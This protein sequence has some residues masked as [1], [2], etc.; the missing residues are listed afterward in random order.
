MPRFFFHI[1]DDQGCVPD[2]EGIV[3]ANMDEAWVEALR[4]ARD[5][6]ADQLRDDKAMEGQKIEIT[7]A[8]GQVLETLAF[9][10]AL[11]PGDAPGIEHPPNRAVG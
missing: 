2:E 8:A 7:D 4:T 5:I 3:L 6:V 1:R 9:K 10:E 11:G